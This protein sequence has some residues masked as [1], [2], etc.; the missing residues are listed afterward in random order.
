MPY[1]ERQR[2]LEQVKEYEAKLASLS[3]E[4]LNALYQ[5]EKAKEGAA[6]SA[7]A[8]REEQARFFNSPRARADLTHWAKAA[9]WTLEEATALSFGKSPELVNWKSLEGYRNVSPFPAEYA[10]VRQ[11][12][13]RAKNSKQLYDPVYPGIFLAWA[14][15][16]DI[17]Y[18]DELQK[19]V[20]K[21]GQ[22]VAD[23][24]TAYD[25]LKT[26][27]DTLELS[28]VEL[29]EKTKQIVAE[30]AKI[31]TAWADEKDTLLEQIMALR[32]AEK[33]LNPKERESLLKLIIAMAVEGYGHDPRA[34][35]STTASEIVGD[36]DKLGLHLDPD[37]VRK[38]LREAA[39][40]MSPELKRD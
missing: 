23:W 13:T 12:A 32:A 24:K 20:T 3:S 17:G 31:T 1:D 18:P 5:E 26:S 33:P 40:L 6:L 25:D 38:W 35:R 21:Y 30:R 11:L 16:N 34:G 22:N 4:E 19:L 36:L 9:Y 15:R 37:T 29:T 8:E 28:F 27:F 10:K 7:K 14:K 39:E 2:Q